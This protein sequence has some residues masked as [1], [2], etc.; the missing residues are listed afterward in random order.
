MFDFLCCDSNATLLWEEIL[1]PSSISPLPALISMQIRIMKDNTTPDASNHWPISWVILSLFLFLGFILS[2]WSE[3]RLIC[4]EFI[5]CWQTVC[6]LAELYANEASC[7]RSCYC[8]IF[9]QSVFYLMNFGS[10]LYSKLRNLHWEKFKTN[11]LLIC[12]QFVNHQKYSNKLWQTK[13]KIQENYSN[14]STI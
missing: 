11:S 2:L 10:F 6:K 8:S 7:C 12:I 4:I 3:I 5:I 13:R 9:L 14:K 1:C